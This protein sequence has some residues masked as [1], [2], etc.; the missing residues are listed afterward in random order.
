MKSWTSPLICLAAAGVFLLPAATRAAALSAS[1]GEVVEELHGHLLDTM[2]HAETLG[3]GGR[4]QNLSVILPKSFDLGFMAQKCVGRYWAKLDD[5]D[6]VRWVDTFTRLTAANY[7]GRFV[8]FS[9]QHFETL[10]EEPAAHDTV[11]V[12][13]RLVNPGDEDVE[14]HYRLLETDEG[15]RIIDVYL[16]GTVS[17]LALRRSEY[18]SALKR[19]GFEKLVSNVN[20]KIEKLKNSN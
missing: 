16:N 17:E 18:G 20:S 4:V 13:T 6:Q 19:D 15:W 3:Y 10:G 14:L 11:L 2:K 1:P 12:R 9:G 8:G 5:A 7:A